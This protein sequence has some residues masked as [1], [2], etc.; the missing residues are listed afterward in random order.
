MK[1]RWGSFRE[2]YF[3]KIV[4]DELLERTRGRVWVCEVSREGLA[5]MKEQ[6]VFTGVHRA[7]DAMRIRIVGDG[8]A[9]CPAEADE[10]TLEDAYLDIMALAEGEG[11]AA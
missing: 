6:Y 4:F 1:I 2:V 3:A 5:Q 9:E 7:G 8:V 10:P 11:E